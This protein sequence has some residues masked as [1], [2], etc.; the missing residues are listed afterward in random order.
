MN[1]N[2][3]IKLQLL[4][5]KSVFECLVKSFLVSLLYFAE[6]V[7]HDHSSETAGYLIEAI[8]VSSIG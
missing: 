7:P 8:Q 3:Y 1:I 4:I 6:L 2:S 5:P